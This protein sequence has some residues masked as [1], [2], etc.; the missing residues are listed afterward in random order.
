MTKTTIA[1]ITIQY[2]IS[3]T[4]RGKQ[5]KQQFSKIKMQLAI[6]YGLFLAFCLAN[7][8]IISSKFSSLAI[9]FLLL[10]WQGQINVLQSLRYASNS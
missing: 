6:Q 3:D 10:K 8:S 1:I 4:Y 5:T 2:I 9:L 7:I